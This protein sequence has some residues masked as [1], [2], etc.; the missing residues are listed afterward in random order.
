MSFMFTQGDSTPPDISNF[1]HGIYEEAIAVHR[2][3][4]VTWAEPTAWDSKDG[5]VR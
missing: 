1:P 2:F 4:F 5:T 3:A